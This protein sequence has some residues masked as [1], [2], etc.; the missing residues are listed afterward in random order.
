MLIKNYAGCN[1][2][3]EQRTVSFYGITPRSGPPLAARADAKPSGDWT[4]VT[5]DDGSKQWAYKGRPIY[6]WSKDQK[7]GD[8]SGDGVGGVWHVVKG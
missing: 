1:R 7:A 4:V 6:H 5:R 3:P 8:E 2:G